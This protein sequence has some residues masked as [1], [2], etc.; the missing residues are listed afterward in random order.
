MVQQI[1]A[2]GLDQHLLP[3]SQCL[4]GSVVR[5]FNQPMQDKF[6]SLIYTSTSLG[7]FEVNVDL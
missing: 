1:S 2:T 5:L 7:G 3:G 4:R 6:N